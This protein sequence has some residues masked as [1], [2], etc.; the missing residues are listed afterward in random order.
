MTLTDPARLDALSKALMTPVSENI[1][2]T[3]QPATQFES[4]TD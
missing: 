1:Y 3:V 2:R 4:V